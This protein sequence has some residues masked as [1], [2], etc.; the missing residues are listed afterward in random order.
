VRPSAAL[1]R[2]ATVYRPGSS[3]RRVRSVT[4]GVRRADPPR[5]AGQPPRAA[6]QVDADTGDRTG[7]RE[8]QPA[9]A[10]AAADDR[11]AA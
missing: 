7:Q 11:H 2:T 5:D 8:R 3:G 6:A 1:G 10:P 4:R 9:G